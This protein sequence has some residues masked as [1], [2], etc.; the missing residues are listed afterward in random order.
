MTCPGA[1][2]VAGDMLSF[3]FAGGGTTTPASTFNYTLRAG[4]L[5]ANGTG[6]VTKIG[7][8]T[9]AVTGIETYSGNTIVSNGTLEM[10]GALNN[11]VTVSGGLLDGN[12]SVYGSVNV[13][14]GGTLGAGSAAGPGVLYSYSTVSLAGAVK[15]RIDNTGGAMNVDSVRQMTGLNYGGT[16]T[17]TNVTS[18]GTPLAVGNTFT[19]FTSAAYSGNFSAITLPELGGGLAWS[20]ANLAVNGTIQV[21][22]GVSTSSPLITSS[23]SQNVL[24]L[25]WPL[26]HTGWRLLVQTNHLALGISTNLNDWAT[27]GD[28]AFTNKVSVPVLPTGPAEFYRLVYP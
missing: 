8:G 15:L 24:N 16:L 6:S 3:A 1:Y 11:G 2:Y 7:A 14:L 17:V 19:L 25:S 12:G 26:D 22:D 27:V 20:V 18:D 23:V 13:L 28:S 10:D 5:V 21:V 9:L 4:D